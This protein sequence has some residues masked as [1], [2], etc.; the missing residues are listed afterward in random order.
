MC[1]AS[2]VS[3]GGREGSPCPCVFCILCRLGKDAGG[4][5][6]RGGRRGGANFSEHLLFLKRFMVP[7]IQKHL[8]LN[9]RISF[10][11]LWKTHKVAKKA[12]ITPNFPN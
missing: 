8:V 9:N 5:N 3:Q 12:K 6:G 11:K 10:W 4:S 1:A 7:P 2:S